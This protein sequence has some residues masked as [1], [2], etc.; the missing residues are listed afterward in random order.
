MNL[1]RVTTAGQIYGVNV[2]NTKAYTPY[3]AAEKAANIMPWRAKED[4]AQQTVI[5]LDG[6]KQTW[7]F[8]PEGK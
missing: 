4:I 2:F 6:S 1:Y 8:E 5:I 3:D 7:T